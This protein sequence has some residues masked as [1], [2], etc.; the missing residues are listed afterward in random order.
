MAQARHAIRAAAEAAGAAVGDLA[1]AGDAGP[2]PARP[3]VRLGDL[4]LSGLLYQLRDDPRV[5]AFAERELG[6]LLAY[7]E[8]AGTDLVQVLVS[9]LAA[10]GN[11]AEAAKRAGLSRPT[12][13]ERLRQIEQL[14]EVSVDSAESRV[15]LHAALIVLRERGDL[16]RPGRA[17]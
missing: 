13:Y 11:K 3:Y 9:Y 4:R 12:L 14:G 17:R 6:P 15:A 10:G 1:R 7:D 8:R 16:A 2:R 5:L